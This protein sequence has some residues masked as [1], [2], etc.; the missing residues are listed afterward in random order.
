MD[1]AKICLTSFIYGDKYQQ[2]IPLLLY[3]INK[4]YPEYDVVLFIYGDLNHF[5]RKT[6][7]DLNYYNRYKIVENAFSE[8]KKMTPIISQSLRWVLW[9]NS[10][11]N[12]DYIYI[13]DIDMIYIR[14]PIPLHQQH[15]IHMQ[16]TGLCFDNM[17]RK[18]KREKNLFSLARRYKYARFRS[19]GE[20]LFGNPVEYRASGLHFIKVKDYYSSL[21]VEKLSKYKQDILNG[22]WLNYTMV[23]NDEVLL[24][25]IL[26]RE[27]LH[28]EK[29]AIQ[30]NSYAS[31]SF[32]NP[33]RPEFR[34]HHGIHLGTFRGGEDKYPEILKSDTYAFYVQKYKEEYLKDGVYQDIIK[35][36][37]SFIREEI[38]KMR[39]YY[40]VY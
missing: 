36:S 28:P 15:T 10:F 18:I 6:L 11:S 13:V 35:N 25:H 3:S 20:F 29:L 8:C 4:S 34:P 32:N 37:P 31:L 33:E 1:S 16:T 23:P 2:Y 39:A 21:N 7:I 19:L 9:D 24:Y 30:S 27:G 14:E 40:E 12:Y 26:E 38:K 5:I 17:R 22:N